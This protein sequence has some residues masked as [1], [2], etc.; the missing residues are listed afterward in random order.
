MEPVFAHCGILPNNSASKQ[1]VT[2]RARPPLALGDDLQRRPPHSIQNNMLIMFA[3]SRSL[4][5]KLV[6][7]PADAG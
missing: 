1:S 2:G 3:E 4:R 5:R 6:P 7:H